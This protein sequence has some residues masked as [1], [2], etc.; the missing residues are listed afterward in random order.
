M[1]LEPVTRSNKD[2][3]KV[4]IRLTH[5]AG[6]VAYI[7]TSMTLHKSGLRKG[8]IADPLI[9]SNCAILIKKY[10]DKLNRVDISTWTVQEVSQYLT[11]ESEVQSI[12]FATF[13]EQY[14]RNMR[15]SNRERPANNYQAAVNS[16]KRYLDKDDIAF[17]DI[18]AILL[19][20]WIDSLAYTSRAK[21]LYPICIKKLFEEGC[22]QYNDYD[23]DIVRISNQPFRSVT[24]PQADV[25]SERHAD[26][27]AIRRIVNE[28]P[29]T[30]RERL[31]HDVVL[32]V[33]HL[34]GINTIDIYELKP[35]SLKN[36]KL[37][38]NRHKTRAVRRDKAYF[39]ITIP[40]QILHLFEKNK[41][42]TGLFA[43]SKMYTTPSIFAAAVNKGLKSL[44][45]RIPDAPAVTAYWFR[46]AWA[47]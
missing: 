47:F 20:G 1:K 34:A 9:L 32:L 10:I 3:K 33:L 35:S 16:L 8:K 44:C 39:E 23:R 17:A 38:Y 27:D 30:D 42:A 41:E 14:I 18:T 28:P 43:Y 11:A 6:K 26:I 36:G 7:Q 22:K 4:Y 29:L 12:S 31:A 2:M 46:H 21:N 45:R 5:K 15:K 25:P 37:C 19:R 24:I 13:A 40:E